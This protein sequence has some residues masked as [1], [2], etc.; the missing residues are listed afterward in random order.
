MT[1]PPRLPNQR[2]VHLDL[3]GYIQAQVD[4]IFQVATAF[5]QPEGSH[6][7]APLWDSQL[8]QH[9]ENE[10]SEAHSC[11]GTLKTMVDLSIDLRHG[12][13]TEGK[14]ISGKT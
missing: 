9:G 5:P 4:A 7:R 12:E 1:L 3:T 14:N 10:Q 11:P 8:N 2:G 6:H 13:E